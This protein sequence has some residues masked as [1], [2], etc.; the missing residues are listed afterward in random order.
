MGGKFTKTNVVCIKNFPITKRPRKRGE[1]ESSGSRQ[2]SPA[3]MKITHIPCLEDNYAYLYQFIISILI[4]WSLIFFFFFFV[5]NHWLIRYWLCNR[6]EGSSMRAL[7]KQRRWTR[8]NRRRSSGRRRRWAPIS[9]SY[10]PLTITGHLLLLIFYLFFWLRYFL[11]L[12]ITLW[13]LKDSHF[14]FQN[15]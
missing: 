5:W 2:Q 1:I 12:L 15:L 13:V 9:S 14:Y 7:M 4:W 11:S 3:A 8:W 6:I 10:S